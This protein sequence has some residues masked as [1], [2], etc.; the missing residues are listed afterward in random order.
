MFMLCVSYEYIATEA[1][2][3]AFFARCIIEG[4]A[5]DLFSSEP[6]RPHRARNYQEH[7]KLL[8]DIRGAYISN[9][10]RLHEDY[11]LSLDLHAASSRGD[12]ASD[13]FGPVRPPTARAGSFANSTA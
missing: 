5:S 11:W 4:R 12:G 6:V 8:E 13:S 9:T 1:L 2:A 10:A 3:E 7:L